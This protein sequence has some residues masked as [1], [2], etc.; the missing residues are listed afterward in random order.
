MIVNNSSKLT[1]FIIIFFN[2][3]ILLNSIKP[4][5]ANYI[6][7]NDNLDLPILPNTKFYLTATPKN[8]SANSDRAVIDFQ[9]VD[10]KGL[11]NKGAPLYSPFDGYAIYTKSPNNSGILEVT[12]LDKKW[13]IV[14]AHIANDIKLAENL[15][16]SYPKHVA[17]GELIAYQGDSGY[18]QKGEKF[19]VHVHFEVFKLEKNNYTNDNKII[20][21]CS[22]LNLER[23]CNW[24]DASG[25]VLFIS[26]R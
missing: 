22:T 5:K 18:I 6:F 20:D 16:N 1:K 7:N 17:K 19:P 26:N 8:H 25:Y 15:I 3:I 10:E 11:I 13:R 23:Q 24:I 21:I 14:I 9:I 12:S 2:I 4:V